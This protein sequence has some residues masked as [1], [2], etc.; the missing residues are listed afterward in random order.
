[1]AAMHESPTKSLPPG[2]EFRNPSMLDSKAVTDLLN[3]RIE[4]DFGTAFLRPGAVLEQWQ[5]PGFHPAFDSRVIFDRRGWLVGYV[6]AWTSHHSPQ[7]WIWGCIHPGFEGRGL[8]TILLRWAEARVKAELYA[9]EPG[10]RFAPRTVPGAARPQV[11]ALYHNLGWTCLGAQL[12]VLDI[13]YGAMRLYHQAVRP[14]ITGEVY[15]KELRP[16]Q[17]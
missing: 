2:F 15:E 3:L 17:N 8:G 16:A 4:S 13:H 6:E 1:M 11:T 10:L 12:R 9:L 14:A 5:T 7:P